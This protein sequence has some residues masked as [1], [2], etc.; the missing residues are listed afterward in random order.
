LAGEQ[1]ATILSVSYDQALLKTREL[2]LRQ[3]NDYVVTSALGFTEALEC[4]RTCH[5]D[6]FILGHSIPLKDKLE[7]IKVFQTRCAAPILALRKMG[8][9]APDGAD[10]HADPNDIDSLLRSVKKL[11]AGGTVGV[12]QV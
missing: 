6:L 8:E 11:L 4:C 3:P 5:F 9:V 10:A 7:L 1:L 2:L 12:D